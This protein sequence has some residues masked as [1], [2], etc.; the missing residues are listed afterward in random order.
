[1]CGWCCCSAAWRWRRRSWWRASP[2]P[3]S[4]SASRPGSTIRCARR[5]PNRCRSRAAIWR[6]IATIS[7]SVALEMANDLTR[8]GQFL[9]ADPSV[10]AEVLGDAD[11]AA[12][13]D[14]GGDLRPAHQAGA[15][16]GRPVR[17][18]GRRTAAASRDQRRHRVATW[19]CWPPATARACRPWCGSNSTPPLMLMIG[20]PVDPPILEHMA[21]TEQAVAE[22]QRLDE[23]RS[24]LQIAFAWI[25]AHRRAAGAAGRGA[26]RPG[27]RQPDRAPDRPP[28]PCRRTCARR[29]PRRARGGG[30]DRRRTGGSVTR[31]QPDDRPA[32]RAARRA[33]GRLQPDR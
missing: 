18:H 33:D 23:N 31:L 15:R 21:R 25:F 7:A 24:W 1:M 26:D 2:S 30:A 8:A 3:S 6:S 20:R 32:C 5:S 13:A 14:R 10:F 9:S 11:D 17:R 28:D 16:R 4:I 29:R 22:Y 27:A 19:W 12:R